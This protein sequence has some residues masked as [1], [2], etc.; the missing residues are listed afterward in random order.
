MGT[1]IIKRINVKDFIHVLKS[2]NKI[3]VNP[4]ALDRLS[5]S[6]RALFKSEQL[7]KILIYEN[8]RGIGLQTNG[9]YCLFYRRNFGFIKIILEFKIDGIEIVIFMNVENMYNLERLKNEK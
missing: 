3:S 1:R 4:H 5:E 9:R 8:P 7:L 2:S 6:Q